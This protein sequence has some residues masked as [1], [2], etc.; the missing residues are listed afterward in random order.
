MPAWAAVCT[1]S[2]AIAEL[3]LGFEVPINTVDYV[4]LREPEATDEGETLIADRHKWSVCTS[5]L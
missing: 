4:D 3:P 2:S 5:M 1:W